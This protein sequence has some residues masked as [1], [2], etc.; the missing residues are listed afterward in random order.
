MKYSTLPAKKQK[1][2][3][4][5]VLLVFALALS[6]PVYFLLNTVYSQLETEAYFHS[7]H[8][9]QTLVDQIDLNLQH[10]LETEQNRPI[11]EYQFFNVMENPLLSETASVKFSP[12]SEVPPKTD[13]KGLIG[14]F[15]IN[16]DGSFHIPALPELEQDVISGLSLAELESR[17]KLKQ[18]MLTLLSIKIAEEEPKTTIV[19]NKD[20]AKPGLEPNKRR[21]LKH[22]VKSTLESLSSLKQLDLSP[23]YSDGFYKNSVQKKG[24]SL[25]KF[26][27][28]TKK[29]KTRKEIVQLPDQAM[30]SSYFNRSLA[31][32]KPQAEYIDNSLN[33]TQEPHSI[34]NI[35]SVE[36]EVTPLQLLLIGT[37]YFCFYRYIWHDNIRYT[38]GFIVNGHDFFTAT[39]QPLVNNTL[40]SS[41][42]LV[43]DDSSFK[44]SIKIGNTEQQYNLYTHRLAMPF[45]KLQ[46]FVNASQLTQ[47]PGSFL[48]DLLAFSIFSIFSLGCIAFYNLLS[49]Q[50]DLAKQQQNFISAVSHELKTPLTSIRMYAEMLRSGW[51]GDDNKKQS[52]FDFIFFESERL[53]RLINNVLQLAR[54]GYNKQKPAIITISAQNLLDRI[55]SIID[56]Q[57]QASSFQLNLIPPPKTTHSISIKVDEDAFFQIVINLVDNALK[58]AKTANNKTIDI[59]FKPSKNRKQIHFFIR[60]YGIGINKNQQKKIFQLFYR[61]EDELTRTTPGTG[62]GLAL[63]AQLAE[64]MDARIEVSNKTPG[65]EFSIN[66]KTTI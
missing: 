54:F 60:D 64:T 56:A 42:S 17:L 59:G 13:L 41:L 5:W 12:L 27:N 31:Q 38:Q 50:I 20:N 16:T 3:L 8:Q 48:I 19:A 11:A 23:E 4:A 24:N 40:F 66:L 26:R 1:Q 58:F 22:R 51:V 28:T 55:P 9:A 2:R 21:E 6:I 52:Y 45:Q 34:I 29:I 53:S 37:E 33:T 43:S 36:S 32:I 49:K 15:Q 30:A 7:R 63:V 14:Y 47:I 57:I 61:S 62:I 18:K 65:A 44:E 10:I 46:L 39:T 35:L 25:H